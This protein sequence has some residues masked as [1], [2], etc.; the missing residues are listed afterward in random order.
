MITIYAASQKGYEVVKHLI[1]HGITNLRVVGAKDSGV[2]NDYY[3]EIK[4]LCKQHS[5]L[6]VDRKLNGRTGYNEYGIAISWRYLLPSD[7]LIVLHDSPL[8]RY[9]G[10]C[11]IPNMLINGESELA[12]TALYASDDYDCGD[13]IYQSS[14]PI[15]YPIKVQ[16]AIDALIPAYC[17]IVLRLVRDINE[18]T[19]PAGTPQSDE[20]SYGLWRDEDDYRIDWSKSA[21]YIK[22]FV[23]A[24]GAPYMGASALVGDELIRIRDCEVYPNQVS[25]EERS[26][27]V[28]KIMF[29]R[30]DFPVVVCGTGLLKITNMD[31][32]LKGFRVRFR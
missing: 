5:V 12:V 4:S 2:L 18:N 24:V 6:H 1:A 22:R 8:P 16:Q 17:N 31:A 21:E 10:F 29:M 15:G 25:I 26:R 9:R 3:D 13:I 23:D 19:L 14:V 30:G 32:K 27:A 7:K 11:P 20:A 28:G